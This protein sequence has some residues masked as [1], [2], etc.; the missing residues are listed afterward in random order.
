MRTYYEHTEEGQ[1][2]TEELMSTF[3]S[4]SMSRVTVFSAIRRFAK[5]E[6]PLRIPREALWPVEVPYDDIYNYS[7]EHLA[8]D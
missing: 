4:L 1:L 6:Y 7:F 3:S 5:Y 2:G 8:G